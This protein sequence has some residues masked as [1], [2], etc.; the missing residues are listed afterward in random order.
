M[1]LKA[2]AIAAI[3]GYMVL[4]LIELKTNHV[5][6]ELALQEYRRILWAITIFNSIATIAVVMA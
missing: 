2:I 1:I 4:G 6:F 3:W 5:T